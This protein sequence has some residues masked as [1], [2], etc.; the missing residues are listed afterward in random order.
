MTVLQGEIALR[1]VKRGSLQDLLKR[2]L[3]KLLRH[4]A[5]GAVS[6]TKAS[7]QQL[8]RRLCSRTWNR[9]HKSL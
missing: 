9:S 8:G 2:G 5:V 3:G 7:C 6:L 1:I 4:F